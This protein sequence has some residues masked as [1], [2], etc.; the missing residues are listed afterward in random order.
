MRYV[1]GS[2]LMVMIVS[3]SPAAA[4]GLEDFSRF[5][6]ALGKEV[7]IV[8]HDGRATEG[9][10]ETATSDRVLLR[11]GGDARWFTAAEIANAERLKDDSSDG[12]WRGALWALVFALIPNQGYRNAGEAWR[13]IGLGFVIF[14]A[15][16]Y[17]FDA[18]NTNRQRLYRAPGAAPALKLSWRF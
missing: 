15:A 8:D 7:S 2:V 14:P 3:A 4:Q 5:A 18:A 9:V 16:G 10:V 17:L 11:V 12:A 1:L 6:K 13:G